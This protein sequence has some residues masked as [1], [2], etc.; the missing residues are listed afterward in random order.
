M[1]EQNI[2]IYIYVYIH[3]YVYIHIYI[4]TYVHTYIPADLLAY[5]PCKVNTFRKGDK[6]EVTSNGIQVGIECK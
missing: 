5:F 6:N 2:Y 1:N 4:Y 3:V